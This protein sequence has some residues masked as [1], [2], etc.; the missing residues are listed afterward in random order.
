MGHAARNPTFRSLSAMRESK[1]EGRKRSRE[2]RAE[3]GEKDREGREDSRGGREEIRKAKREENNMGREE[4]RGIGEE[5]GKKIREKGSLGREESRQSRAATKLD[6]CLF[7][8]D[9]F[10][11]LSCEVI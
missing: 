7:D 6:G 2:S 1:E 4:S 11:L 9:P 5:I 3:T 8:K 10:F